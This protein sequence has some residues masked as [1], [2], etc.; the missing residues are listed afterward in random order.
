MP[1]RRIFFRRCRV[2]L[3]N[4]SYWSKFHVNI[5]TGSEI[6]TIF[7]YKRLIRNPEIGNTPVCVLANIWRMG[8][9]SD[10]KFCLNVSN[11]NLLYAANV[12]FIAFTVSELLK[13]NQHT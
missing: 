5:V 2:S 13:E 3:V 4:F 6:M 8:Q 1:P 10:T 7:V 12:R 9:V 11:K